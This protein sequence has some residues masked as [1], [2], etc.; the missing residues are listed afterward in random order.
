MVFA[1]QRNFLQHSGRASET[2]AN[3]FVI[4][5]EVIH[6]KHTPNNRISETITRLL[7]TI[8]RL[9]LP[10]PLSSVEVTEE[11]EGVQKRYEECFQSA[12]C[13]TLYFLRSL[14]TNAQHSISPRHCPSARLL[15]RL[16]APIPHT[17]APTP[18]PPTATTHSTTTLPPTPIWARNPFRNPPRNLPSCAASRQHP[19]DSHCGYINDPG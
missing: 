10:C 14:L 18:T 16:A 19:A 12:F 6:R 13:K 11:E 5:T 8:T 17:P 1:Q 9:R 3:S 15:K 7:E 4:G 2:H